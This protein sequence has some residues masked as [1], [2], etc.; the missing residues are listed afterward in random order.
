MRK[1]VLLVLLCGAGYTASSQANG[2]IK[3]KVLDTLFKQTLSEAT[4]SVLLSKDSTPVTFAVADSKGAFE[5]KNIDTG[6]YRLLISFQGYRPF[7]KNFRISK[8]VKAIDFGT[9]YMEKQ[10]VML[11]EVIVER[12]PITVKKDTVEFSAGSFRTKPNSTAEDLLKKLPGV[13]V[14]K[15]GNVKAQGEDIQK[16]YVDGKEFFGNDPKLATKNITADMIE[17][18]Q[19]FDDMSDQAKF[20]RIDD[21]SRAKTINIKLKKDKRKGY[22][23]RALAGVG[24]EGRYESSLSFNRFN[25]DRRISFIGASNNVNKQ[26]FAFSDIVSSMGGFGARG[27]GGGGG[28][29]GGMMRMAGMF[30]GGFN[31]GGGGNGISRTL[32]SGLNYSDKWGSKVDVTGS[33]F[34]SSSDTRTT[35]SSLRQN[36]FGD[37]VTLQDQQTVSRNKNQN[38]RFNLR[39]E[40]YI[41]SMNSILYTPTVT[42]QHSES[43]S[44]DTLSA[45]LSKPGLNYVVLDGTTR[46]ENQ[47][48]GVNVNNNLL[49]RHK[50]RKLGR[51]FTLGFNNSINRSEG[52]GINFAP[53]TYYRPDA[54]VLAVSSQDLKSFQDTRSNNNVV[55]TSYTEPIGKNKILEL[56][57]AY[58]NNHSTSD[59]RAFDFNS[60]TGNYDKVNNLQTNYFENDYLSHRFGTNFRVQAAKYNFQF[61]V[62]VQQSELSNF[63]RRKKFTGEDTVINL[64]QDFTNFFPT[65]NFNYNFTKTK[66]LRINYRGRT[67][68]PSVS[69]LQDVQDISDPLYIRQGNPGLSQEFN[70]NI[71]IN[72]NSFNIATFRYISANIRFD[73]TSNKIVNRTDTIQRGKQLITP[74][75]MDGAFSTSSFIT[76]GLPLRGKLKGSNFNFNNSVSYNRDVNIVNGQDN[77]VNNLVITQTVGINLD[78]KKK[79]NIG[80]NSSVSYNRATY[81]LIDSLNTRFFSQTYS[82]DISYTTKNNLTISTDFDYY[83]STGRAEGF[84]QSLPLWNAYIA[85]Q[86]FKK[87]NGEIR[88]SVNDIL[89]Q[90][91]SVTRT[92]GD[93]YVIDTRTL[94][95]KRYF[96]LSFIF[97]L[98]R[99]GGNQ[100]QMQIPGQFRR[101]AERMRIGN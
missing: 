59:R 24:T 30:P 3:G 80:L 74:V 39:M 92:V 17:S 14:D 10:S 56:N 47:R 64:K 9:I 82:A 4:I 12:P 15:D 65:A 40:Y 86:I 53:Y 79:V 28:N 101:Q 88:F 75:N 33:Y 35:R 100:N 5:V 71:S 18:V 55:S 31:T 45:R 22:F 70:N 97:N 11:D 61:G 54:S 60:A 58:T 13:Q 90:N 84:N 34:Y 36:S 42:V 41:D 32:S 25:G 50:F 21:G 85:Q 27:A 63:S 77:A 89:N 98:N 46:N 91:E 66:S 83:I 2:N 73:Q 68:Q 76:L 69:Q 96:M 81:K 37:S 87:K 29:M 26:G 99:S 1:F 44:R 8:D 20:S 51:T 62:G 95:L 6:S 19:V 94:V 78:I 48:D 7:S 38:H 57:Y 23:G 16:V 52:E 49:F 43:E 72:Y 67:N 93:T